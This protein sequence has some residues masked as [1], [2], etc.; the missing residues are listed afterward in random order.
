[1]KQIITGETGSG[2]TYYAINEAKKR[3][4]FIYT[5][6]CR[7]LCY[8]TAIKYGTNR[9]KITT[10]EIDIK[11]L[12][13]N[14]F[15]VFESLKGL[16]YNDYNTL[17]IDECH[18]L[19]DI[20]RNYNLI[21]AINQFEGN[22][23]LVTATK[24]FNETKE[25]LLHGFSN[26]HLKSRVNFQI[27]RI[28]VPKF[29]KRVKAGEPSIYFHKYKEAC[30]KFGGHPINSD[31]PCDER[32]FAQL[33][34]E[35]GEIKFIE[36][37]S[38]LAQGVNFPATNVCIEYNQHDN[39]ETISQKLGRLGRFGFGHDKTQIMTYAAI[40]D[41]EEL[42][43][44]EQEIHEGKP[45]KEIND[46]YKR[47]LANMTNNPKIAFILLRPLEDYEVCKI[48]ENNGRNYLFFDNYSIASIDI[49][50]KNGLDIEQYMLKSEVKKYFKIKQSR[51]NLENII[52]TELD[53]K[54]AKGEI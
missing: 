9:D 39:N 12:N 23:F 50:L 30:G 45:M 49:L 37:T 38:V 2:K 4:R 42:E 31:T 25:P 53:L 35:R 43:F 21:F 5:A 3:G 34:F 16:E 11:G 7:Q 20:T 13:E 52:T 27:K 41:C 51:K 28:T 54:T 14:C 19:T 29:F 44:E 32:L 46:I 33:A 22:I 24:N 15:S 6:P 26:N 36:S 48:V 10:G 1:M 40:K 47:K 8:E 18:F 17:I